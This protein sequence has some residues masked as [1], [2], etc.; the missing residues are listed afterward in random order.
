MAHYE[1]VLTD[2][3]QA[4]RVAI[5]TYIAR[6]IPR[7]YIAED[8]TQDVFVRLWNVRQTICETTIRSFVFTV[9]NNIITDHLRRYL[10]R[11]AYNDYVAYFGEHI[12]NST[13]ERVVAD[14]LAETELRVVTAMPP[15]RRKVYMMSRFEDM[16]I[17]DIAAE[18]SMGRRTVETHLFIGRRTMRKELRRCV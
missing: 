12:S 6:R 5:C 1:Q 9:A 3:F 18:L 13:A 17:D 16:S 11:R 10:R 7:A 2:Y 8:L 15:K 14:D 4:N